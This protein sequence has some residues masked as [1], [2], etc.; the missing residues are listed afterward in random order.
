MNDD[1]P[2]DFETAKERWHRAVRYAESVKYGKAE[3]YTLARA[4]AERLAREAVK[5]MEGGGEA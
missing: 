4:E 5:R 3:A 2:T 1:P